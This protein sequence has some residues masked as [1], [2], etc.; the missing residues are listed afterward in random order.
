MTTVMLK[1][2]EQLANHLPPRQQL[3][4]IRHLTLQLAATAPR[5]PSKSLADSWQGVPDNFD[6][7]TALKEIR[8]EWLNVSACR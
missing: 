8:S 6:V 1:E 7:D 2:V 5:L 3:E 4:L